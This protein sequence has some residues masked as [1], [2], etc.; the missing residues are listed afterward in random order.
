MRVLLLILSLLSLGTDTSQSMSALAKTDGQRLLVQHQ[1]ARE[2]AW[3]LPPGD[4]IERE[5]KGDELQFYRLQLKQGEFFQVQVVPY[6]IHLGVLLLKVHGEQADLIKATRI[7]DF[8]ERVRLSYEVKESGEYILSVKAFRSSKAYTY[9]ISRRDDQPTTDADRRTELAE[10]LV[11]QAIQL[12]EKG[13]RESRL[14]AIRNL[15]QAKI[16]WSELREYYWFAATLNRLGIALSGLGDKQNAL[17][18]FNL[19]LSVRDH[20]NDEYLEATILNNTG[21]LYSDLGYRGRALEFFLQALDIETR[22]GNE[23]GLRTVSNNIGLVYS[24]LGEKQL[25]LYAFRRALPAERSLDDGQLEA[26]ILNNIG[27]V[28]ASDQNKQDALMNYKLA[29]SIQE[30]IE[31]PVGKARTWNNIGL[32]YHNSGDN[33]NALKYYNLAL[34]LRRVVGDKLGEANTLS[35][36]AGVYSSIG[37]KKEALGLYNLAL[38]L[39]RAVGDKSGEAMTLSD[40]MLEWNDAGNRNMAIFFGKQSVNRLQELREGIQGLDE[41]TQ[42]TYLST[43]AGPYHSLAELLIEQG[44]LPEA[45]YVLGLLKEEEYLGFVRRD[46]DEIKALAKSVGLN[47]VERKAFAEYASLAEDLTR[48]GQQYQVLFDKRANLGGKPLPDHD[49]EAEF[50]KLSKL[51]ASTNA[52]FERFLARLASQLGRDRR[53]VNLRIKR[54]E[55]LKSDLREIGADVV[56]ISTFVLPDRYRVILTT[57]QTQI[58]RKT[59]IKAA[60]L[61]RKLTCFLMA[62]KD[63]RLDPRP[64]GEELYNILIKPFARDLEKGKVKTILWSLDGPLRYIPVSALWDGPHQQ[65]L[66]ERYQSAVITLGRNSRLFREVTRDWRALGAGVSAKWPGFPELPGVAR[67]LRSIVRDERLTG[68]TEGVLSGRRLLDGEFT[69]SALKDLMPSQENGRHFNLIHLAS[70]FKLRQTRDASFLLLG[71]G[72]QLS[73]TEF[74]K[75]PR[76]KLTGVELL[77]L[78]ACDTGVGIDKGDGSEFESF[79]MLAEKNGAKAVLATL[80]PVADCS[81]GEFM[82]EFYR[83]Y[84]QARQQ[85]M[86]KAAA[87]QQA[88]QAMLSGAIQAPAGCHVRTGGGDTKPDVCTMRPFSPDPAKPFAHPYYWAPFVLFGNWR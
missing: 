13:T 34:T 86:T 55:E 22:L 66:G 28:Y 49:E 53:V 36:I 83:L 19:A 33:T 88:Q 59:E 82:R 70:H 6:G 2:Q 8:T 85:G 80:W 46:T 25:A 42:R 50:Q 23:Q 77:T 35:N 38:P 39:T 74:D 21:L 10:D 69:D 63:P 15:N 47:D 71:D 75:D 81:T 68:E 61:N 24:A 16:I 56:L 67:E 3:Q 11:D 48:I 52:T 12:L 9:Q 26:T 60:A 29:L 44:R 78:S 40:L 57:G 18:N 79:G 41:E 76:L 4:M 5:I 51:L 58:D 73:L 72:T 1:D 45:Q 37:R 7:R 17:T 64:I 43:V 87:L 31:D 32:V 27:A 30:R 14:S 84:Q 20:I 62:L 65:Y 54:I